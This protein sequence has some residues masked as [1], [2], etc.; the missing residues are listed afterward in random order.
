MASFPSFQSFLQEV[1]QG[2]VGKYA[3]KRLSTAQKQKYADGEGSVAGFEEKTKALIKDVFVA[4]GLD[5]LAW[6]DLAA[7]LA[8]MEGAYRLLKRRTWTYAADER[9]VVWML[10]SHFFM[11][12]LA[13]HAAFWQ[14]EAPID[15]GM[16]G[17]RFWYLPC[18]D[19]SARVPR[20][21]LPV[22]QVVEWLLELLGE[23]VPEIARKRKDMEGARADGR[24][25]F[26]R[27]LENWR[28][29]TTTPEIKYIEDYFHDDACLEFDGVFRLA[30]E[31]SDDAHF[32]AALRFVQ[33]K[34]LNAESLHAEISL[35]RDC[36]EQVLA[37]TADH[38]VR[39]AFVRQLASRYA[40]P[41]MQLVRRRLR[42]ARM[43][44]DGYERLLGLLCPGVDP[45][46]ADPERNKLLQLS[47]IFQYVYNLTIQASEAEAAE[48][49]S[50]DA[51][52]ERQLRPWEALTLYLAIL[53]SLH[54][55]GGGIK[56]LAEYLTRQF[57]GFQPGA[58]LEDQ[59]GMTIEA[60]RVVSGRRMAWLQQSAKEQEALQSLFQRF[61]SGSSWQAL[62]AEGSFWVVSQAAQDPRIGEKIRNQCVSRLE[63]LAVSPAERMAV[64]RT[65]LHSLLNPEDARYRPDVKAR[66]DACL[67]QAEQ[68]SCASDWRA[69]LLH[70]RA[71][72]LL[73]QNDFAGAAATCRRALKCCKERG[74]GPLEGE[75]ARDVMGIE[76]ADR[77]LVRDNH[78]GLFLKMWGEGIFEG[79]TIPELEDAARLASDYFWE[80]LYRPYPGVERKEPMA[81]RLVEEAIHAFVEADPEKL[82]SWI[83]RN[84]RVLQQALPGAQEDSVLML[85]LKMGLHVEERLVRRR[86]LWPSFLT[87]FS[88][89]AR[90]TAS[91]R[92]AV[93]TLM[94][95]A[96]EQL[97]IADFKGQTPLMLVAESGESA[98]VESMLMAGVDPDRQDYRGRTALHAAVRSRNAE[99]LELLIRS[100]CRT[101]LEM[102]EGQTVL[103]TAVLFGN[104]LALAR[105]LDV[106]PALFD[107]KDLAHQMTALELVEWLLDVPEA[108]AHLEEEMGLNGR[109]A[110]TVEELGEIQAML[111]E[112]GVRRAVEDC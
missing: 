14:S 31:V 93:R 3:S 87:E 110:A 46:E 71:R 39:M 94:A 57:M 65:M 20:V 77:R 28:R 89:V 73:A 68:N 61:R 48:G 86:M 108:R 58:P 1:H 52:F 15:A 109:R 29:G 101:D 50:D 21:Q 91:W 18:L 85:F 8:G 45:L 98:L 22:P 16:P 6:D 9:Q 43:V 81:Q 76:L 56:A 88:N 79:T 47:M 66:V 5:P 97:A 12:G 53:P 102:H 62:Q 96:P 64:T 75:V 11:P 106:A 38:D 19:P 35:P 10:A 82:Q 105:L 30:P 78:E 27:S 99:C 70:Y 51:W 34:G 59:I 33:Q 7:N 17:G 90:V 83:E 26:R 44:Q 54:G 63:E 36:L 104:V 42:F 41:S 74:F 84:R 55:E 37:G 40:Q 80:T 69:P 24:E 60:D 100:R 95:F 107:R 49:L 92:E 32:E 4:L 13:R 25:G 72:H 103:H 67:E 112:A 2:L 111:R 23:P